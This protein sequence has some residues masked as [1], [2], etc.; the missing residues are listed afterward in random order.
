MIFSNRFVDFICNTIPNVGCSI[1]EVIFSSRRTVMRP[2]RSILY[3]TVRQAPFYN[4]WLP[5]GGIQGNPFRGYI[6]HSVIITVDYQPVVSVT[7]AFLS[8]TH[9]HRIDV[10]SRTSKILFIPKDIP[11]TATLG[12]SSGDWVK[13]FVLASNRYTSMVRKIDNTSIYEYGA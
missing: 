10:S 7:R 2:T 3:S 13:L 8:S 12:A 9:Q 5:R 1:E 11:H 6:L 4:G